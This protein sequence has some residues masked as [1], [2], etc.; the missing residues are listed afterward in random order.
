MTLKGLPEGVEAVEIRI[1]QAGEL[2]FRSGH[3][4]MADGGYPVSM[5]IVRVAEG[6][7]RAYVIEDDTYSIVR[8]LPQPKRFTANFLIESE[9]DEL[10]MR[11]YLS[12][13]PGFTGVTEE[14]AAASAE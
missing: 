14:S 3:V 7:R 11:N 8:C 13:I 6:Y 2:I 9:P 12:R 1:P 5:L 10:A 4:E